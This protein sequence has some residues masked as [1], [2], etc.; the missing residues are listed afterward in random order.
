V[1][2]REGYHRAKGAYR[3]FAVGIPA[4]RPLVHAMRPDT[5]KT[6]CHQ[7]PEHW[8]NVEP[9]TV[10]CYRCRK[11]IERTEAQVVA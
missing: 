3:Y 4:R 5:G 8:T 2:P 6:A 9:A 1:K 11:W 7:A 10:T